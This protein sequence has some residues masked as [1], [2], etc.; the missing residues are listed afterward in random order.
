MAHAGALFAV[1]L[2]A[3]RFS[4]AL[5]RREMPALLL[6]GAA[7]ALIA[8]TSHAAAASPAGFAAIGIVDD[9]LHLLCGGFW[10]GGLGVL[11]AI[12]AL[13]SEAPRL[14]KALSLF[15]DW[16]MIAVALLALTGLVNAATIVLGGE[17]H[18]SRLYV[19][20]LAAKLVLVAAMLLALANHFRLLP[21]LGAA[22]DAGPCLRGNIIWELGLGAGGDR[23]CS[24]AGIVDRRRSSAA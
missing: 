9:G 20:V 5:F 11:A 13:R 17:G 2:L 22:T 19:G 14:L 18:A 21:R 4:Q 3:C 15:A 6:S 16:A 12:M 7:L 1:L 24:A 8:V 10:I 23:A